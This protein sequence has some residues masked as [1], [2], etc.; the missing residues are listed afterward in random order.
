MNTKII[1]NTL[2]NSALRLLESEGKSLRGGEILKY[3]IADY[4]FSRTKWLSSNN[5]RVVP[6]ELIDDDRT[7]L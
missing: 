7:Y 4:Y 3:V 1:E 6:I 5:M 2:E